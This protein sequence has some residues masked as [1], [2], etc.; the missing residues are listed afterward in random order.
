M[1]K[2]DLQNWPNCQTINSETEG[3]HWSFEDVAVIC[4]RA[5]LEMKTS[6]PCFGVTQYDFARPYEHFDVA[7]QFSD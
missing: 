5:K 4:Q 2:F 3:I 1:T 6:V 7:D